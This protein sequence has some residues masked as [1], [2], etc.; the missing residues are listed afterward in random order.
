MSNEAVDIVGKGADVF[1]I[2]IF[3]LSQLKCFLPPQHMKTDSN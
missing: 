2:L 3:V 1:L